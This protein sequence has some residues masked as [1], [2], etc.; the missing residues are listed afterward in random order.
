MPDVNKFVRKKVIVI[1]VKVNRLGVRLS[2]F[3]EKKLQ[4]VSESLGLKRSTAVRYLVNEK[5]Q[6]LKKQEN[7]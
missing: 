5:Y 1:D 7:S 3:E 2:D 6:E 4:Y